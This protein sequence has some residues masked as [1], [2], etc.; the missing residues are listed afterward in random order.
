MVA[1]IEILC[2]H[3]LLNEGYKRS[4][5]NNK[6]GNKNFPCNL[7][8]LSHFSDKIGDVSLYVNCGSVVSKLFHSVKSLIIILLIITYII[9]YEMTNLWLRLTKGKN[10]VFL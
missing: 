3:G 9:L 7:Q 4:V 5:K 1:L 6:I 2:T 10:T 8:L